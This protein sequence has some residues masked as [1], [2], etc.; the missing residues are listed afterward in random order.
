MNFNVCS[1]KT[2]HISANVAVQSLKVYISTICFI[3]QVRQY[4]M[5]NSQVPQNK[6]ET[7]FKLFRNIINN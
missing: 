2:N 4:S 1:T 7:N 6:A 3:I 5:V